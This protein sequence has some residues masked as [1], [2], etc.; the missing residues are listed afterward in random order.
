MLNAHRLSLLLKETGTMWVTKVWRRTPR[1]RKTLR[2]AL[3]A[4]NA[5]AS[6]VELNNKKE[7]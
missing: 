7:L 2:N 6:I 4:L 5:A 1:R 3:N